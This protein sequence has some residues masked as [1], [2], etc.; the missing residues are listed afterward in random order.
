MNSLYLRTRYLLLLPHGQLEHQESVWMTLETM[1]SPYVAVVDCETNKR[2]VP[3][4]GATE[5]LR[6]ARGESH[7]LAHIKKAEVA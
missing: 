7:G 1:V 4:N 5:L 6:D 2:Y 3:P